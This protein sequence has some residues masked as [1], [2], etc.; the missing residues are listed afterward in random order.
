M[1]DNS[2]DNG[3]TN[4]MDHRLAHI[5]NILS[6]RDWLA[7]NSFTVADLLMAGVKRKSC[8]DVDC[9]GGNQRRLRDMR[10][11]DEKYGYSIAPYTPQKWT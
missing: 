6:K 2:D 3:L 7:A 11:S 4:W 10:D 8:N 1:P 9:G 5:E